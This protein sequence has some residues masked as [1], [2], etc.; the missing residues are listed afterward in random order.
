[1]PATAPRVGI[2]L[3]VPESWYEFEVHPS[4]RTAAIKRMVAERAEL[5]PIVAEN[6]DT[7]VKA[8]QKLSREA[9]EGGA[10]YCGCM[11]EG[12]DGI[13]L[14]ASITVQIVRASS[15]GQALPTDPASIASALSEKEARNPHDT[16]RK[17]S[18][19]DLP[20]A[21]TAARANSVE[22]IQPAGEQHAVRAVLTQTFVPVPDSEYVAVITGSSP[23]IDLA[24]EFHDL[25][26]AVT[27]TF[28][29]VTPD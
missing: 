3:K 7:I 29:F 9:W 15:E 21:G 13:P 28:R 10:V 23:V 8:L 1:M 11:A 19:V 17:V 14:I 5:Y 25:F 4:T 27:S 26:D 6:Y 18:L 12:F 22:D 16:W 24:A 20:G 2:S